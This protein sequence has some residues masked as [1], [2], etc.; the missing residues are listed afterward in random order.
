MGYIPFKT[1]EV[2]TQDTYVELES[3]SDS[4]LHRITGKDNRQEANSTAH[5]GLLLLLHLLCEQIQ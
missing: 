4:L 1:S 5:H 3:P 2:N